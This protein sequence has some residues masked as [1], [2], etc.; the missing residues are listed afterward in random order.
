MKIQ[1]IFNC[2]MSKFIENFTKSFIMVYG[3]MDTPQAEIG[4]KCNGAN[5][6]GFDP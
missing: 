1:D 5:K 2:K 4:S 3:S 6:H